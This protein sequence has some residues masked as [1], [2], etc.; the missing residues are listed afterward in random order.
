MTTIVG[1]DPGELAGVALLA[2][3]DD[4]PVFVHGGTVQ[5][6]KSSL[7]FGRMEKLLLTVAAAAK[8]Q[9]STFIEIPGGK[10]GSKRKKRPP[11]TWFR[12]GQKTG[13]LQRLCIE[14]GLG[15]PEEIGSEKWPR[16][17][18]V[19]VGKVNEGSH[20]IREASQIIEGF[21]DWAKLQPYESGADKNRLVTVAEAA[22]IG[23]G[24]WV[25]SGGGGK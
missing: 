25:D 12:L 5:G 8:S 13:W 11:I 10:G 19:R 1:I 22:L 16:A 7:W 9:P 4:K 15:M 18:K 17:C 3:M 23:W 20:R 14:H 6:K 21:G 24:G 2:V